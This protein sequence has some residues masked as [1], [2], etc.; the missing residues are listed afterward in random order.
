M[1][2]EKYWKDIRYQ[3]MANPVKEKQGEVE[4][5]LQQIAVRILDRQPYGDGEAA[6]FAQQIT[7][8]SIDKLKELLPEFKCAVTCA[9]VMKE[10]G[11]LH[12][13]AACI[14]NQATDGSI[15]VQLTT[16]TMQCVITVF[17]FAI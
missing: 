16:E 14:W 7:A 10:E 9:I 13:S 1:G 3:M 12:L 6:K 8:A 15:K 4:T 17:A 5:E 11:A 2:E